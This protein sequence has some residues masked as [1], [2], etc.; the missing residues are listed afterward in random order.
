MN[1]N[2]HKLEKPN[3]IEGYEINTITR[4]TATGYLYTQIRAQYTQI[5]AQYTNSSALHKFKRYTQIVKNTTYKFKHTQKHRNGFQQPSPHCT[6]LISVP[7]LLLA[8]L[9]INLPAYCSRGVV[10][11]TYLSV[12]LF[13]FCTRRTIS[14]MVFCF[15][16]FIYTEASS[17]FAAGKATLQKQSLLLSIVVPVDG[18]IRLYQKR[19][20]YT[21]RQ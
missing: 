4:T 19:L 21:H 16:I 6:L 8:K 12:V 18:G 20:Y 7:I 15:F 2:S 5:R 17:S 3:E 9:I 11:S 10:P 14:R 1:A 13:P